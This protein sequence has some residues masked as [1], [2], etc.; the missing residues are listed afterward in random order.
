MPQSFPEF[1]LPPTAC[2]AIQK[3]LL[4]WSLDAGR[5]LLPWRGNR[6]PYQVLVSEMMLVQTT[7][8][9]V[10]EPYSRFLTRFPTLESLA[11]ATQEEV[12]KQWEGLGYYRRARQ[13]HETAQRVVAEHGG[14]LPS[15]PEALLA[16]P[17]IGRYIAGAIASFAFDKPEPILEANTQ[18]VL[19][20][21]IGWPKEISLSESQRQ[22]W[23]VAS[24]LV[25][26]KEPGAFNQALMDL[27]ATVCTPSAPLCLLCPLRDHCRA[28]AE[29]RQD[30][31]PVKRAKGQVLRGTEECA[32]I[33]GTKGWLMV[34]RASERL[35]ADFWEFPTRHVD[36][37]DPAGRSDTPAHAD[38]LVKVVKKL[39]G[40]DVELDATDPA[41][42][43]NYSV[44]RYRMKLAAFS[45]RTV[46]GEFRPNSHVQAVRWVNSDESRTL[47]MS[48]PTRKLI[49]A[50]RL[51]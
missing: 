10:L 18:R 25:P 37:A 20:R 13:L 11:L 42:A 5:A 4:A 36:G 2:R 34:Q 29:G 26:Q 6:D 49:A 41:H 8:K 44:T 24:Q 51:S 27:G 46:N 19:A 32:V 21:L 43:V 40:V 48:S 35:W 30:E 7:V 33:V 12:L 31:L 39:V 17:G 38:S 3:R 45:G 50:L 28:H 16:L 14:E 1:E 23:S 22:L 47:T 15:D 9:A